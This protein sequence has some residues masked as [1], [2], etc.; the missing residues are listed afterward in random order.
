MGK[1]DVLEVGTHSGDPSPPCVVLF[2]GY[3]A[4]CHDLASLERACQLPQKVRWIF[5]QGPLEVPIAPGWSGRAWFPIN[6]VA[7]DQ[8]VRS[9][10]AHELAQLRPEGLDRAR[11]LA[12]DM[13]AQIGVPKT[14]IVLGGFSQGAMLACDLFLSSPENFAGL[15][16]LSGSLIDE[17]NWRRL[18]AHKSGSRFFQSHGRQDSVLPFVLGEQLSELLQGA[19]C[20]GHLYEFRGGHEIPAAVTREMSSYLRFVMEGNFRGQ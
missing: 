9:G 11:A 5:P 14:K 16:I 13:I 10:Q 4:D 7:W 20:D 6:V 19:G 17:P 2:H 12:L 18:A 3:G 8:A 1:I 15:V